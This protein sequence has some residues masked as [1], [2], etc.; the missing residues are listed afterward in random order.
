MTGLLLGDAVD[1]FCVTGGTGSRDALPFRE[2]V[3]GSRERALFG[4][5][6]YADRSLGVSLMTCLQEGAKQSCTKCLRASE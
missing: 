1:P 3:G 6:G 4:V 2:V 5:D